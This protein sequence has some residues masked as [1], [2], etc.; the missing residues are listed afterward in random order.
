MD[1]PPPGGA[2]GDAPVLPGGLIE[3]SVIGLIMT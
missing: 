1:A 3:E 2:P